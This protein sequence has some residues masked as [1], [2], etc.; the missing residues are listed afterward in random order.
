MPTSPA[1]P[2]DS[3]TDLGMGDQ[4]CLLV[5]VRGTEHSLG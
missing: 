1:T 3:P 2:D 4:E 5:S